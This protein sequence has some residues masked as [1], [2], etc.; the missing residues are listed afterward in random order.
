MIVFDAD[1]IMAGET[2]VR[3]AQMMDHYPRAGIIQ[4][5][6]TTVN[7]DSLFGRLQQFASRAYGPMLT[8]GQRFWQLGEGYYWGHNAI[9]RT[10]PFM[11]Y[12]GLSRLPGQAPLGGEILSHDFVEAALMGRA[13]WE[14]WVVHD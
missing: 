8:A 2:L 13:G 6:P 7:C 10:A 14:V 5:A 3:L 9:I 11:D 1:S 4:T 12:C